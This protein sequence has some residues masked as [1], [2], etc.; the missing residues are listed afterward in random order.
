MLVKSREKRRKQNEVDI[1]KNIPKLSDI[2]V[3]DS[4]QEFADYTYLGHN[5]YSRQFAVTIYPEQTWIGWLDDISRIGDINI[6][7][8]IETSPN[9]SVINQL[10]RKLVQNQSQ[11]QTY[12]KQGNIAHLP[13]LEQMISDLEE[14]RT[15]I[16]TN[17]DKLF[18]ATI[19]IKVNAKTKEELDEKTLQI[20]SEFAKKTAIIRCLTFRQ[21]ETWKNLL[22]LG[23]KAI[24]NFERNMTTGGIATLIPI[25]S[26]NLSHNTGIFIGRNIFTN[27]PVYIDTFIGPPSLPNPHVFVCGTSG[28]GKSVALK[29]MAARNMVS[30]SANIFFLDVE[31]EYAKLCK[32][33]GGKII[34]IRQGENA[35]INPFELEI[36]KKGNQEF[37]NILDKISEI[38]ALLATICRNYMNRTLNANEITEIEIVI[39]ELYMERG[40][41]SDVNSLYEKTGGKLDNG[42]Y[43]VGKIKKKMPTLTDFQKK[44]SKRDNCPELA[45]L[46]IPFLRGNSLGIFDCESTIDTSTEIVS[47]DMSDIKDEFT[48]LYAS[49]VLLTWAWQKFVLKNKDKKKIIVCDEAWLFLKYKESA[50]FLVNVARRRKKVSSIITYSKSIYT[51]VFIL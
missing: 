27:A 14:L 3:P 5:R 13:E 41:T 51:R 37:I 18:F 17:R 39:N 16:Q 49:F 21:L 33:L 46:L 24:D 48:K 31:G 1:F 7:I 32:Q 34:K 11:Y 4:I 42:K 8:K 38:R 25:S 23:E 26:P 47:F 12:Q 44:L 28:G 10:T 45:K 35:G 43:V 2:L 36:D 6:S 9:A 29:L 50:E 20:E 19:F 30:N 15:L 22:P 40:I